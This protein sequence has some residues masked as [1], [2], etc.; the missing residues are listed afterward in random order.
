MLTYEEVQLILGWY[1]VVQDHA[2]GFLGPL[3]SE[4]VGK[5]EE[6]KIELLE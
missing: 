2:E 1:D 5:L 3:D 4:L 6:L